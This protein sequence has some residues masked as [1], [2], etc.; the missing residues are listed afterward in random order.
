MASRKDVPR[1]S[2]P[3]GPLYLASS[4]R[5]S[6]FL[7]VIYDSK[8][9]D[10]RA[11]HAWKSVHYCGDSLDQISA[12]IGIEMPDFIAITNILSKDTGIALEIARRAKAVCPKTVV[13]IGGSHATASPEDILAC[14]EV[15]IAAIG[16]GE[17]TIVEL[18]QRIE[19]GETFRDVKGIAFRNDIGAIVVNPQRIPANELPP[20][21]DYSLVDLERYF[22]ITAQGFGARP[23]V[24]GKR[25]LSVFSSRGCPFRCFFCGAHAIVGRKFRTYPADIVLQHIRDMVERYGIDSVDFEDDNVSGDR[26]RFE[27]IVDGL[28]DFHPRLAWATPNG[29]RA[30]TLTDRALLQKMK[31]SGLQYLTMGVESGDQQFLSKTIKKALDL[32]VVVE[33]A[34]LFRQVGIPLNAFFIVGFPD[35]TLEQINNTLSFAHMLHRR[36]AVYPFISFAIPLKG[37]DMYR[38]CVDKGY[39]TD[40]ITPELLTHSASYKGRGLILT[41][42][43]TPEQVSVLLRKFNRDVFIDELKNMAFNP[44]LALTRVRSI[45][46]SLPRAWRY[47]FS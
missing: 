32:G 24:I 30:D 5:R 22:Q 19:A 7:P 31:A 9:S 8:I 15:D 45:L 13:A 21:P 46:R 39:L 1:I 18:A 36:H 33:L 47:F 37:T 26:R 6:G 29:A 12:R 44:V 25:T 17:Q 20:F 41:R 35:E 10:V 43:F 2:V 27:A 4:L 38:I 34:K 11:I 40:A 3:Y 28:A 14:P 42:D 23:F 16:E